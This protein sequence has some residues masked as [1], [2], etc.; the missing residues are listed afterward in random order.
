M[1]DDEREPR[2]VGEADGVGVPMVEREGGGGAKARGVTCGCTLNPATGE[3]R[4]CEK[5][6]PTKTAKGQALEAMDRAGQLLKKGSVTG[7]DVVTMR[8]YLDFAMERVRSIEELKKARPVRK[9]KGDSS[10]VEAPF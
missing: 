10:V 5:H 1:S 2:S 8:S 4:Y 9:A 3:R 6:E 7:L